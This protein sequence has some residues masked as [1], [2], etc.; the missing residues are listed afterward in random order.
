M[1]SAKKALYLAISCMV[2]MLLL[3]SAAPIE[4]AMAATSYYVKGDTGLD[5]NPGTLASPFQTIQKCATVMVAGDTCYIRTGVYREPTIVPLN[6][7]TSS[8]NLIKFAAYNGEL[9]TISG[10]DLITGWT[11]ESGSIYKA[12]MNWDILNAAGKVE[13]V[14]IVDN[15]LTGKAKWPNNVNDIL[16]TSSWAEVDSKTA[17]PLTEYTIT[18]SALSPFST[19][20]WNGATIVS[21]AGVSYAAISSTI[22][23]FSANTLHFLPW[24]NGSTPYAPA[25]NDFYYLTDSLN[26]LDIANEWYKNSATNTLYLWAPGG[27]S[28]A[29]HTVEAKKREYGFDLSNKSYIEVNGIRF[30]A[31]SVKTTSTTNNIKMDRINMQGATQ[32]VEGSYNEI[33]NS[34]I[35]K[36]IGSGVILTGQNHRI[37][38]NYIHDI[39]YAAGNYNPGI[40][41]DGKNHLI[42]HN[43]IARGAASLLMGAPSNSVIQYNNIYDAAI[44]TDD[45]GIV[46]FGNTDYG[47]TEVHH[48][49]IHDNKS[50]DTVQARGLY[51]DNLA[52]DIIAYKNVIWNAGASGIYVN[53]YNYFQLYY[54]NTIY[55]SSNLKSVGTG[56]GNQYMNNIV[57]DGFIYPQSDITSNNFTSGNPLYVN[58]AASD[59]HLQST[60]PAKD[61]GRVLTGVTEGYVGSAPDIGA[62]EYGGTDWTPGHNFTTPPNPV[63]TINNFAYKNKITNPSYELGG[64]D[65]FHGSLEGWTITG[66]VENILNNAWNYNEASYSQMNYGAAGIHGGGNIQQTITGLTPNTS[67]VFSSWGKMGGQLIQAET[68]NYRSVSNHLIV[69][70]YVAPLRDGDYLGYANVTFNSLYD[71]IALGLNFTKAGGY[72]DIRLDS[73]TGTL[74]GTMTLTDNFAGWISPE[75]PITVAAGTHNLYLVV[76]GTANVDLATLDVIKLTSSTMSD[77]MKIGV[78]N[79]NGTSDVNTNITSTLWQNNYLLFTTG[80]TNTTATI[81][82]DK[83]TGNY[84]G[85][86]DNLGVIQSYLPDG[87]T[88][89]DSFEIGFGNWTT[90]YGTP[91]T[92]T[93]QKRSGKY[94]YIL[95]EDQDSIQRLMPAATNKVA[96]VK[97]FDDASDTNLQ[98]QAYVDST[99][100]TTKVALGVN[101]NISTTKY[102]YRIGS[103]TLATS[104][105]RSTGWHEL[106]FDYRSGTDVKL[107][108]DGLLVGTSTAV[109]S[110]NNISLGDTGGDGLTG[111]VY[112]DDITVQ[113]ALPFEFSDSFENVTPFGNWATEG[114]TPS[115]STTQKY[116]GS[117]SFVINEDKD[118]IVHSM[119]G[120]T[121]KVAVVRFYDDAADL[122]MY[123]I[124]RV[125][126]GTTLAAIGVLTGT[127]TTK[128]AYRVGATWAASTVTRTTGWHEFTFDYRSGTDVKLYIDG[129]LVT[130]S[131]VVTAF[132][133]IYLGDPSMDG[134][135]GTVYY[136][137]VVVQESL[138]FTLPIFS[139]SFENGFS[140]NWVNVNGTPSTSTTQQYS[141]NVS[142]VMNQ[143]GD[144]IYHSMP[145][146]NKV[147]VVRF[148]DD[149]AD[150]SM[151]AITRVDPGTT[152][153]AVGVLTAT[154]T[155]KYA[156]RI[157]ATWAASNVTRT[158][159]WHEFTFDYRSG[160]DVKLYIDGI[161][162]TTSTAVTSFNII[163]LGDPS[164]DGLTGNVYFDDVVVQESLPFL[165]PTFGDSFET[166]FGNWATVNGTPTTS[167]S[168]KYS[169]NAS[170]VMDADQDYIVHSMAG[171]TNKVATVR[172]Y[173]DAADLSMYT[174]T[175]VDPGTTLAA[176]GVLTGTS[177]TK[178][179]YR[180]GATWVASNVT[181]TTGWHKFT[182]DYRSGTD[183]KLYIDD[184]LV[185]TS[186]AVTAFNVIYLGDPSADGLSGAV[187]FDEISVQENL[188]P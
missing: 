44:L 129:V 114:G 23:S 182:F 154:S 132:N 46:Y 22:T 39:N 68:F 42:S 10:A 188:M 4:Q 64:P 113:N 160:T 75:I 102:S 150:L 157:G 2:W 77:S 35:S 59:F 50:R 161:L 142:Y 170:Y 7:G 168:Q 123:A 107:Y 119:A 96:V 159:G 143:D 24:A 83:P 38:N 169:G 41:M 128:Y 152:L 18:D 81:Y 89:Y 65:P 184:V 25:V 176:I 66:N 106:T 139:D 91:T 92:S 135:T 67:Y 45:V 47:N 84:V 27:D 131:T 140:P 72:I 97:F 181:R 151:Y 40:L 58:P 185:T 61:R 17:D 82:A 11:L 12:T 171:L 93:T 86:F 5:T 21:V 164:V 122:S 138:P 87:A 153:A 100:N 165:L 70:D 137:D 15:Q 101:T 187:Y 163:Y 43:T 125:D 133:L 36:T 121:N 117:A 48:N 166:G 26:A 148:Y 60:S 179:A 57:Y 8:T 174:I 13:N 177:T 134:L 80:A 76:R 1:I 63:F 99:S 28:P 95:N 14:L 19:G 103:N 79:F 54:N 73:V 141:G 162:V 175:R 85:Y 78:K 90:V 108:I 56:Y 172:F 31:T 130:T 53:Y 144:Y 32:K 104:V 127:S 186:T 33:K 71:R 55:N 126:P 37:I 69:N 109:T 178:Y 20:Y 116:N 52:T 51:L 49:W 30:V 111:N 136:D 147:V 120:L 74:L 29:N 145:S 118:Y 146:T 149:A 34:E 155:T 112:F 9:V 156:Y 110:F 3:I 158:T 115:T 16:T 105:K 94:S 62:Y 180:V 88:F 124:T 183:V 6:S 173:D 98:A 167:T